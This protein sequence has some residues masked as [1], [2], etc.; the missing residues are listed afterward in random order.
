MKSKAATLETELKSK[1]IDARVIIEDS[2]YYKPDTDGERIDNIPYWGNKAYY[3]YPRTT[4]TGTSSFSPP[5]PWYV[6]SSY[7]SGEQ[8]VGSGVFKSSEEAQNYPVDRDW[9]YCSAGEDANGD[10]QYSCTYV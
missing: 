5:S 10:F 1:G 9:R 7:K 3:S 2:F 4:A 8:V 6:V